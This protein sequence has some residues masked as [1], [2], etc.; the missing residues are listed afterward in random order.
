MLLIATALILLSCKKAN[1]AEKPPFS[2]IPQLFPVAPGFVD[3]ASGIADSYSNPGYLWVEQDSGNPP[4]LRLIKHDGSQGKRI[5]LKNASNRDWEEMQISNGPDPSK[6]YIYLGDIGDNDGVY[7]NCSIYRFE[8]PSSN[9]DTV[10]NYEKIQYHYS[11][12]PRDAEAM[13]IDPSTKDIFIITKRDAYSRIYKL[14]YPQSTTSVNTAEFIFELPYKGVVGSA[15]SADAKE[16]LV[17]TY[18]A[19]YYYRKASS[20]SITDALKQ[21]GTAV[22]YQVEIQG[23]ALCFAN[24]NSGFYTLSEKSMAPAVKLNFYKRN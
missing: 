23:E 5:V 21:S 9:A 19:I 6:K 10:F 17:K 4:D 8:E 22:S 1:P 3:E 20:Q 7:A 14:A 11:D 13:L 2:G 24:D 12:G 15:I 18:G 16:I